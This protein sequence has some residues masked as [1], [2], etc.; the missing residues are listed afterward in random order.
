MGDKST[1][2]DTMKA[3]NVPCVPGSEGLVKDDADCLRIVEEIG[4][5]VMIKAT[6]G[7]GG[8]GMRLVTKQEDVLP[9]YKQAQQ[10][11]EAAFGNGAVYIE[12]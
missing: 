9:L 5:P 10:E 3:A 7:G 4:L 6:A 1:A 12:R 2:K 11:A 8:R